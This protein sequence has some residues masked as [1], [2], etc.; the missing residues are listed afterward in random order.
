MN[1]LTLHGDGPQEKA[2]I[3]I[4]YALLGT[5]FFVPLQ[6]YIMEIFF[7]AAF[8]LGIFYFVKYGVPAYTGKPLVYPALAFAATA[9]VS[10][11]GA[12]Q[13]W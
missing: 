4:V 2:R 8:I 3:R 10:L 13:A 1:L 6:L 11:A 9:L 5:A 12:P 7:S